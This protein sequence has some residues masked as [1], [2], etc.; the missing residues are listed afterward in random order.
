MKRTFRILFVNR[1][2]NPAERQL[3]EFLN[4]HSFA[5]TDYNIMAVPASMTGRDILCFY[6][7]ERELK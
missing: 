7:S 4:R 3:L 2:T 6:Y 5:P 1:E